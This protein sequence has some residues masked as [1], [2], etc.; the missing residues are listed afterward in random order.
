[1]F[2]V[3]EGR[4]QET[5]HALEESTISKSTFHEDVNWVVISGIDRNKPKPNLLLGDDYSTWNED[6]PKAHDIPISRDNDQV[7]CKGNMEGFPNSDAALEVQ[8]SQ[9]L[10]NVA[11]QDDLLGQSGGHELTV[12]TSTAC[13]P[14]N[15]DKQ[16]ILSSNAAKE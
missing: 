11:G 2:L 15:D 1:M 12:A 14:N 5:I 9:C 10:G 8:A 6:G 4:Q 16:P 7:T 3:L 13:L